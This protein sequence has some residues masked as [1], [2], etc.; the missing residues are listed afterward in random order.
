MT[1]RKA[2]LHP[3]EQ[4]A[5]Q[6][7]ELDAF[8]RM[9]N[10]SEGTFSLSIAIC[11]SPALRDHIIAHITREMKDITVVR[12]P[13]DTPDIFDFVQRQTTDGHPRAV[14][15][16]DMDK[17]ISSDHADRVLQGINVSRESWQLTHE[18]PV[19]FWLPDYAAQLL[20]ARARDLWSW[21]SHHFEFIS[22]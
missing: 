21:M 1:K 7:G 14:F 2:T 20:S 18:C 11:N 4:T 15:V 6:R 3:F 10:V 5:Y 22:E 16:V 19:V 17:A 8:R 13:G 9:L 12:V